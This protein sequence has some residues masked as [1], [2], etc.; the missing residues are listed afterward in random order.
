MFQVTG[1]DVGEVSETMSEDR[2]RLL[3]LLTELSFERRKVTLASGRESD[4][5]IDVRNTA[6]HPEGNVRC[7]R[8]LWERL[9]AS[10]P[11]FTA[12]AGPSIGADPLIAAIAYTSW[13]ANQPVPAMMVR[14]EA[15]GHGVGGLI[16]GARHIP[17]GSAVAV[18]ED[19]LT[20]G[21]SALRCIENIRRCGYNPV[22]LIVVVDRE[23]GGREHVET[24]AQIPVEAL[25]SRS[26]FIE[27][28]SL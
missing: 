17:E 21:G 7:G 9:M 22:R 16:A 20:T 2:Q 1:N 5:Y 6:L 25:F 15:K 28:A 19:V 4:F 12:V 27:E 18:V 13:L 8:L 26:D 11:E 3:S 10:G 14:K 23:D 24:S